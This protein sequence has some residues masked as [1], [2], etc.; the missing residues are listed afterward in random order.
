MSDSRN[1]QY[2]NVDKEDVDNQ[3][4]ITDIDI[5]I[6]AISEIEPRPKAIRNK[7]RHKKLSKTQQRIVWRRNKIQEYLIKGLNLHEIADQMQ[8]SY[9]VIWDDYDIMRKEARENMQRNHIPD[10]PIQIKL[11]CDSLNQVIKILYEIQDLELMGL[12]NRHPSDNVRV[13]ALSQIREAIKLKLEILTSQS[14]VE[15][16]L[17]F[18]ESTKQLKIVKD[19]FSQD[20]KEIRELDKEESLPIM[21]AL[22]NK[23]VNNGNNIMTLEEGQEDKE[24]NEELEQQEEEESEIASHYSEPITQETITEHEH[25]SNSN[26][27]DA[28][29]MRRIQQQREQYQQHKEEL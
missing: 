26:I 5:S 17:K 1:I 13:L 18:V 4:N 2:D 20:M 23:D 14:A 21:D 24:D 6:P 29:T 11:A 9:K 3:R 12:Q 19:K 22:T 15:D 7:R 28:D 10:L 16:A 8:I 27:I 25:N